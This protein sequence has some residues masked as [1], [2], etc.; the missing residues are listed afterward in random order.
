M[1]LD[2]VVGDDNVTVSALDQVELNRDALDGM[3]VG[4]QRATTHDR[5]VSEVFGDAVEVR[6]YASQDEA[7]LDLVAGRLD[8]IMADSVAMLDGFLNTEQGADFSYIGPGFSIPEY[9]G[10]GAGIALRKNEDELREKLNAAI[11]QIRA[12]GTYTAIQDKYFDFDVYG[13]CPTC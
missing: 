2:I 6:R 1:D 10:E 9:H 11:E 8:L 4:V 13:G 7:Y 3:V 12:D 5:F